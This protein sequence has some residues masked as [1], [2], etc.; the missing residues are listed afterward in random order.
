M[1]AYRISSSLEIVG[2]SDDDW[3]GCVDTLE[4]TSGYIFNGVG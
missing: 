2:Y 3:V 4:N 1:L